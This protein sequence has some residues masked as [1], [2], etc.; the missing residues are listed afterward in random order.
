MQIIC[1]HVFTFIFTHI[2]T[3]YPP[4]QHLRDTT[5][6][7]SCMERVVFHSE[8]FSVMQTERAELLE[9]TEGSN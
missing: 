3:E 6:V 5:H 9:G 7:D 8:Y 2:C 4:W 1:L